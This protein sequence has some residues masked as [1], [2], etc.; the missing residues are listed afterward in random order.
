MMAN[1]QYGFNGLNNR[2]G[3]RHI[4]STGGRAKT[5]K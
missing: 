2:N 4:T 1:R 3:N 5:Q